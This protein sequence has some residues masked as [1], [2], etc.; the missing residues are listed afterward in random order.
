MEK[1][2]RR[3]DKLAF[4]MIE[5][6]FVIV[7]LGILAAMAMPRI[8]RDLRQEAA[9]NILSAIRYTQHLALMDNVVDPTNLSW[10]QKFWSF[11]KSGCSDNGIYYYIAS[12]TDMD[13]GIGIDREEAAIDVADGGWINGVSG[14]PCETTLV[15]Q[16]FA[17]GTFASKNIFLTKKYG[18]IEDDATMFGSCPGVSTYIGFDYMGRPHGGFADSVSPNYGSVLNADCNLTF[19]FSDGSPNL[20]ITIKKETGYAFIVGQP[21][22]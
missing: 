1:V 15:G 3:G 9:D 21:N 12:D 7:I 18:I 16:V 20:V 17:D 10:Q 5:L 2:Y 22:S 13:A 11:G 6:V 19:S 14:A 8:E 4:T